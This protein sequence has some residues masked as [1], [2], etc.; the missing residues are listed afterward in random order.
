MTERE[1]KR[2]AAFY[3]VDTYVRSGMRVGLGH[4]STMAFALERLA[5]K[6]Q[7]GELENYVGVP[8]SKQ[9]AQ[10]ARSL[11]I[12]LTTLEETPRLDLCIDGADEVDP[13]LNLIK[14]LGG[15]LLREKIVAMAADRMVVIVDE[16]KIVDRLGTKVPLPVEVVPFGWT[17]HENW[18]RGLDCRPEVRRTPEGKKV[19][20]DEG[21]YI[22]DCFFANGL[23]DPARLE[24]IINNRPGIVENGLFLGIADRIV[25][26]SPSAEI[27]VRSRRV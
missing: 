26:S 25:I 7:A 16:S 27:Q 3:A 10:I 13:Q 24:S 23:E 14:G 15:A 6:G 12:P 18:L 11:H 19:V 8:V 17:T 1:L 9:T 22:Y 4:G 2:K 21:N 20:T 5:Q